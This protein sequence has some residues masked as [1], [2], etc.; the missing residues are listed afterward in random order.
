LVGPSISSSSVTPAGGDQFP[1]AAPPGAPNGGHPVTLE[2]TVRL[3]AV[4]L[5]EAEGGYSVLIPALG[6]ATEGDTIEEARANAVEAAEGWLA[7]MHDRHRD[8]AVRVAR[9]EDG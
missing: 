6:C 8:G 9:G 5:P 7:S 1:A 4:A 2:V 3:Q